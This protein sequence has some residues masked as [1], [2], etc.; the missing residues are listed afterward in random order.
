[1]QFDLIDKLR[2][3]DARYKVTA[4]STFLWG[5]VSQGMGLFNKFSVHDDVMNFEVGATYSS[6]RWMLDL[7]GK[8]ETLLFKQGHFSLPLFNG[9][10]AFVLIAASACLIVRL[11]E[12]RNL[13]FCSFIGGLM[14][15]FPVITSIFGYMFTLH[16]YMVALLF[17]V[18][19]ACCVCLGDTWYLYLAGAVLLGAS[20]GVYQPFFPVGVTLILLYLISF[21][22][23]ADDWKV[24]LKKALLCGLCLAAAL[25]FYLIVN[26]AFLTLYG[27]SINYFGVTSMGGASLAEYLRRAVYTYTEYFYPNIN[28]KYYMYRDRVSII[29]K[30]VVL[31]TVL[32]SVRMTMKLYK[33]NRPNALLCAVLM[34]LFPVCTNLIIVM[35]GQQNVHSVMVYTSLF[36]F[37]YCVWLLDRAEWKPGLLEKSTGFLVTCV[38]ILVLLVF[39]R[40][41]NM[42]YLKATYAQQNAISYFTTL[43]AQIKETD[44]YSDDLPV[45]FLGEIT[46]SSVST[47]DADKIF[48]R[49]FPYGSVDGYLNNY[50]WK[51]FMWQ[52]CGYHPTVVSSEGFADLEEVQAMP[53]Y[54][55]DGSIKVIDGTV[56]VNF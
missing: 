12:V 52:W 32:L 10:L 51:E 14:A 35:A 53:H 6:G 26:R 23:K 38:C 40:Y 7:L 13:F 36:P 37:V 17:A 43:I 11:L 42:A 31:L 25:V 54:P 41:D 30:A 24:L 29:Y 8:L 56:V 15:A 20:L 39:T 34:L 18:L 33:K 16:F 55:D 44:G 2:K 4:V 28:S 46:D 50:R 27:I 48:V 45:T 5:V 47:G 49:L 3:M 1:M 22:A 19:G 21:S 9:M